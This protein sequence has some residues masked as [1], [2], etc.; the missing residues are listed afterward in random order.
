M[1]SLSPKEISPH[2]KGIGDLR[3][4]SQR[5]DRNASTPQSNNT[6]PKPSVR[7]HLQAQHSQ[8]QVHEQRRI[9]VSP[10]AFSP[11]QWCCQR[12]ESRALLPLAP[13]LR[14]HPCAVGPGDVTN[15]FKLPVPP[16]Q[17]GGTMMLQV[18]AD[19]L[20]QSNQTVCSGFLSAEWRA[21]RERGRNV[22]HIYMWWGGTHQ[23][24]TDAN[25]FTYM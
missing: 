4:D 19:V 23:Q 3:F 17:A 5:Q 9:D 25:R 14:V 24:Q 7:F 8:V 10:N 11:K 15:F 20:N 1:C 2:G 13:L 21:R 16:K 6:Q 18:D 12:V 22:S